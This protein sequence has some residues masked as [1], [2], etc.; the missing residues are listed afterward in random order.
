MDQRGYV[1][2]TAV[3]LVY[4]GLGLV[5]EALT[6]LERGADERNGDMI[7]LKVW[8]AWDA[9]RSEQRFEALLAINISLAAR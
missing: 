8:P 5:D 7:L 4:T 9:L 3:A 6:W 2:S 1:P